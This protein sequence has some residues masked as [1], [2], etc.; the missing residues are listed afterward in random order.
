V[1][2][3]PESQ[4]PQGYVKVKVDRIKEIQGPDPNI[5]KKES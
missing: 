5:Y 1:N 4:L 2:K 3:Y